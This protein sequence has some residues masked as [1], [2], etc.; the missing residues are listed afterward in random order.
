M[1]MA[2]YYLNKPLTCAARM[3]AHGSFAPVFI[4]QWRDQMSVHDP[5]ASRLSNPNHKKQSEAPRKAL[6]LLVTVFSFLA[7]LPAAA[8]TTSQEPARPTIEQI[9]REYILQHPEVIIESFRLYKERE[10]T[11]QKEQAKEALSGSLSDLQQDPSS[12]AAG[13]A[14]GVTIVEFFDY[15]CGYCKKAEG[16]IEKLLADH[17]DIRF[18]FKE[19][20]ILGP[21]STLAAKAGLA[22]REQGSYLKF[23]QALMT[24][25]GP[26]TM[27]AIAE[28]AGKQG[29][30]VSRL[31]SDMESPGV[32]AIL[33][34]N[35][36]LGHKVGVRSTPSFVIGS[37]LVSGAI[38]AATFERLIAEAKQGSAP[39]AAP[40]K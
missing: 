11:A 36:D 29:L 19:F 32:Q 34:R 15:H 31:E 5:K 10:Q 1:G 28:L 18:V 6:T 9:V 26:I 17:P 22:A 4:G 27:D 3:P 25:Q 30:D 23:H 33:A 8:Q 16:T 24:L 37:E 20:P 21:E 12:P 38:D 35:H 40:D 2:S 7:L 14:G 39:H 13:T